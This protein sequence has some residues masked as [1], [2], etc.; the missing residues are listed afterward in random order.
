MKHL[1]SLL[2]EQ[3]YNKISYIEV[4]RPHWKTAIYYAVLNSNNVNSVIEWSDDYNQWKLAHQLRANKANAKKEGI[5]LDSNNIVITN[6]QREN[7]EIKATFSDGKVLIIKLNLTD[8][9]NDL[10]SILN[11]NGVSILL[12]EEE[13][14]LIFDYIKGFCKNNVIEDEHPKFYVLTELLKCAQ[15][16]YAKLNDKKQKPFLETIIG[17]GVFYLPTLVAK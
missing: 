10:W 16:L 3:L 9:K 8:F 2:A 7:I 1:L 12:D 11:N 13:A 14:I 15:L 4:C 5:T 17:A 6:C